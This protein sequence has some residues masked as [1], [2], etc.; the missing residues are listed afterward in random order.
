MTS[1][2]TSSPSSAT[3][4][5]T[6]L[7]SP[8]SPLNSPLSSQLYVSEP[9][10]RNQSPPSS[11]ICSHPPP[12]RRLAVGSPSTSSLC[13]APASS[14]PEL[15]SIA[16]ISASKPQPGLPRVSPWW[17]LL[18]MDRLSPHRSARGLGATICRLIGPATTPQKLGILKVRVR[19]P[20]S[21]AV[22]GG[23][24]A[25]HFGRIWRRGFGI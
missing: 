8:A 25:G 15:T 9:N 14:T 7:G 18:L 19:S 20:I 21:L 24:F 22:K 4:L 11:P 16:P 12:P 1:S 6:G 13:A 17:L 10:A 23:G 2:S 5:A 3:I